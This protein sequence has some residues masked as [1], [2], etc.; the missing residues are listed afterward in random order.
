LRSPIDA[1]PGVL[2]LPD[3]PD[4]P[5]AVVR[6]CMPGDAA[7]LTALLWQP[8]V[9]RFLCDDT[10]LPVAALAGMLA[11][12]QDMAGR[13]LG[14]WR[15]DLPGRGLV[16]LCALM[17]IMPAYAGH[18]AMRD[19]VEPLIALDP[20]LWGQG[21]ATRMVMGL[22]RHAR[23]RCGLSR[24]VGV[25]DVPNARSHRMMIRCGFRPL[26]RVPGPKYE[27]VLY[28]RALTADDGA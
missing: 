28:E 3:L 26:D 27:A 11:R 6:L 12:G 10:C 15:I 20:S 14:H 7:D 21:W 2:S 24:L 23:F 16:G 4:L 18:P 8:E 19:G 22:I 13:G 25:V 1:A 17:P 5:D 9:R